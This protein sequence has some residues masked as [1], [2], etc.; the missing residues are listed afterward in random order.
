[1]DTKGIDWE[2]LGEDMTQGI[3]MS[4]VKDI[5]WTKEQ[6][7]FLWDVFEQLGGEHAFEDEL[8][9]RLFTEM[10]TLVDGDLYIVREKETTEDVRKKLT[11][12]GFLEG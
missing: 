9:A 8:K 12:S 1:M 4:R 2:K 6:L 7:D 3:R 5:L 11:R 10:I